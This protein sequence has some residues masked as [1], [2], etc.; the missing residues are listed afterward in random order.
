MNLI[1]TIKAQSPK[2][3]EKE[4]NNNNNNNNNNNKE[5]R[6]GSRLGQRTYNKDLGQARGHTARILVRGY[7]ARRASR[8]RTLICPFEALRR[9]PWL[10]HGKTK[11]Y[12]Q[13]SSKKAIKNPAK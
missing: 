9:G 11:M 7:V 10:T 2:K 12:V 13:I 5:K 1:G 4:G 3:K 6:R 8:P